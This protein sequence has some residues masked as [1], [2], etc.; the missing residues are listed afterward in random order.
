[1]SGATLQVWAVVPVK[2]LSFAKQRLRSVL[3]RGGDDF[4]RALAQRTIGALRGSRSIEGV[5]VVTQDP[6]VAGDARRSGAQVV[7]DRAL[8]LNGA[9]ALGIIAARQRGA[10]VC[11]L[12]PADLALLTPGGCSALIASYAEYRQALGGAVVGLVRCKDGT[13]TNLALFDPGV[14]FQPSY[15]PGSFA[16]HLA[17]A[18][19]MGRELQG[20][21]AAFDIDTVEDLASFARQRGAAA[22]A[23]WLDLLRPDK[24]PA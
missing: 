3:G 6:L 10:D 1:M 19:A 20:G 7:E 23:D 13:G 18:G 21:E 4:A 15:G 9:Y 12:V 16:R 17:A 8:D 11:A 24:I 2:R 22:G 5:L 14:G